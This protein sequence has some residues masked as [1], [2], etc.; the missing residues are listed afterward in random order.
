MDKEKRAGIAKDYGRHE[1]DSGSAEVQMALL[2]ARIRELTEHLKVHP[3]DKH[4][5][6]GLI[7]MVNQRR[8]WQ[9]YLK[10]ENPE[11]YRD[12]CQRLEIRA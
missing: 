3:K 7:T 9:R 4:S 2:T 6:R 8:K 1:T 10:R 12:V 11:K 5:R